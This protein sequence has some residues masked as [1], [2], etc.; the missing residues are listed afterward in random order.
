MKTKYFLGVEVPSSLRGSVEL[1]SFGGTPSLGVLGLEDKVPQGKFV[2]LE[3]KCGV[4][5]P[6]EFWGKTK[7][8]TQH[9]MDEDDSVRQ[10]NSNESRIV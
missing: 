3:P 6:I 7:K 9:V 2:G 1:C 10:Y 8:K 5:A 4:L